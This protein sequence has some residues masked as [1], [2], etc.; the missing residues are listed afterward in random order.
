LKK[1]ENVLIGEP[2][3]GMKGISGGEKRRLA[4]GCEVKRIK[5]IS[6]EA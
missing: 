5:Y 6:I 1:C 2:E 4:F 3:Q